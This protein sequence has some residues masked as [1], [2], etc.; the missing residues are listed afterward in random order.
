MTDFPR[1]GAHEAQSEAPK[2]PGVNVPRPGEGAMHDDRAEPLAL[3]SGDNTQADSNLPGRLH[4]IADSEYLRRMAAE[5]CRIPASIWRSECEGD[6]DIIP[7]AVSEN[8]GRDSANPTP[9][10]Q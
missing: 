6:F 10:R 2:A 9:C 8:T 3:S 1:S 5:A 4:R 7:P